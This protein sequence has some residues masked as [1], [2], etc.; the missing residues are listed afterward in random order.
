MWFLINRKKDYVP[1]TYS[2]EQ[3]EG[4]LEIFCSDPILLEQ[5][6]LKSI[7]ERFCSQ[8][9]RMVYCHSSLSGMM[10]ELLEPIT[11]NAENTLKDLKNFETNSLSQGG[12]LARIYPL[13]E[14]EKVLKERNQ[15]YGLRCLESLGKYD[16]DT[17]SW[18]TPQCLLFEDSTE[19]VE[20]LPKWGMTLNGELWALTMPTL[21]TKE[22][23]F[24]CGENFKGQSRA[25]HIP[26]PTCT[27]VN[28]RG[29]RSC[30]TDD[31]F[32]GLSLA[33]LVEKEPG[34]LW[35]TPTCQEVEHPNAELT[36]TGR[37]KSKNGKNTSH[38]L[39]LAD[40][41]SHREDDGVMNSIPTPCARDYKGTN[42]EE[43]LVYSTGN[44]LNQPPNYVRY[45]LEREKTSF[46]TPGTTGLSNG[47]GNCEKSKQLLQDGVI[48]EEE[49]RS[50]R[51]GN[52]G[53]LNPY[54]VEW[55][56]GWPIGWTSLKPLR[57]KDFLSWYKTALTTWW[58]VDPADAGEIPRVTTENEHR[59]NRLICLG[60][61]QVP[62]C[63]VLSTSILTQK[64][65]LR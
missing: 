59:K 39:G 21:H 17:S 13:Q 34:R 23:D 54:W 9:R 64:E 51:A 16:R 33:Y 43:S 42:N 56:M 45:I 6:N 27:D 63:V 3:G 2:Q 37:R 18:R 26:T 5:L 62:A 36:E 52:G 29:K 49:C 12:F 19:L 48:S 35:P 22:N 10:S 41:V 57:K 8:D 15:A 38:S 60:N 65:K 28:A 50:F 20:T 61:G 47:S 53:Q 7:K 1:F 32:R 14:R 58:D 55:L 31:N 25:R 30:T 24:G 4:Y 46:P 44:R 11:R 40:A